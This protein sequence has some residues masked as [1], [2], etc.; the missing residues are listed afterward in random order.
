MKVKSLKKAVSLSMAAV[1]ALSLTS[2]INTKDVKAAKSV[3]L[4]FG[5]HQSGLP[6]SGI[7]QNLAKE[8]EKHGDFV[9]GNLMNRISLLIS[10][11][12]SSFGQ[13]PIVLPPTIIS[14]EKI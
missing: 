13:S 12:T 7:V 3:T 8:F 2:V 10:E 14:E 11:I 5:S 4:S 9:L 1:M 6:T